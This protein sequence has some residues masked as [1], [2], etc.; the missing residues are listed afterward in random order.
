MKHTH[1]STVQKTM[2]ALLVGIVAVPVTST[3]LFLQQSAVDTLELEP[4]SLRD[5]A[6]G[7]RSRL[8][9]QRRLYW[10]A[11]EQSQRNENF[12][13]PD[14]NDPSTYERVHG[15]APEAEAS[16]DVTTVT[17]LTTNRLETHDRAL[18]RRYTRAG[19][20]PEGLKTFPIT[21]FY[22]LCVNLVGESVKE[23][24]ATGLLNHKAYLRQRFKGS[25]P[26][27]SGFKLRMQMM[28]EA[29]NGYRRDP[30]QLPMRPTYCVM[31]PDCLQ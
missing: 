20:C 11:I 24:P 1:F 10:Q 13:R 16:D 31:N 14:F 23:A 5:A 29:R 19:F 9:A 3:A 30:G 18:L 21:G 25:A 17:S 6:L 2:L 15:S 27:I 26:E 7:D 28:D 8:R 22:E 12:E 4:Q